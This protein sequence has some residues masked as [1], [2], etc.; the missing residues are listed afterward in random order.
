MHENNQL[1]H[2]QNSTTEHESSHF[3]KYDQTLKVCQRHSLMGLKS[4]NEEGIATTN[5]VGWC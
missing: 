5:L 2:M 3:T 1:D 4:K